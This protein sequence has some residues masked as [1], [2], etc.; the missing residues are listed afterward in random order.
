MITNDILLQASALADEFASARPFKHVVIDNFLA[1]RVAEAMLAEFPAETDPAKLVNEFGVANPKKS[2]TDVKSIGGIY[3]DM[4]AYIQSDE[5]IR[6]MEQVTGIPGLRYDPYYY[7]AGTHENFHGAG[8]DPHYDF[9]IHPVTHQHRRLNAIVY[10][11]KD[12]RPEWKGSLSLHSDPWDLQGDQVTT[13]DME[14]NRC[15][16]FETTESSWHSVPLIDQPEE[17]RSR[18]RKSFTI[19]M[20]TDERPRQELAPPHGTVYVQTGLPSHIKAGRVLSESDVQILQSNIQRR[21]EY[22]RQLYRREY[23]FAQSIEDLKTR[24]RELESYGGLPVIGMCRVLRVLRPAY[25]DGWLASEL[26]FEMKPLLDV[27]RI[28][29]TGY[30]PDD[31]GAIDVTLKVGDYELTRKVQG[32]FELVADCRLQAQRPVEVVLKLPAAASVEGL[33][34]RRIVSVLLDAIAIES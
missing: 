1:P 25:T 5:F 15:V 10:L 26:R 18:S 2:I 16:I 32:A 28:R 21:H 31:R 17:F 7:G 9:N 8:L 19:Y 14:F 29:V 34:D 33:P 23:K 22:L 6:F 30:R 4:D 20:Y 24:I 13:I 12:W 27:R 3:A 11:N